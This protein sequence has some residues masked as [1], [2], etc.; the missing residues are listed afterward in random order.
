MGLNN[1]IL[2]GSLMEDL[3][4][5][6]LVE[7]SN[8]VPVNT[9]RPVHTGLQK[10]IQYLGKNKKQVCVLVNYGN[11]VYLPDTELNFL[12]SILQACKLNLG[13][14]AIVNCHAQKISF[15][16]LTEQVM[17]KYLLVFGVEAATIGLPQMPLFNTTVVDDC[18][19]VFAPAAE[20]LNNSQA[21]SRPLKTKLWL[22]LKQMFNVQ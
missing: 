22:C 16:E 7:D 9:I 21:A 18:H 2:S 14:V 1:I 13:D 8:P 10:T 6:H 20:Q 3:Y 5:N 12:T 15:K 19:I 11:D 4:K 17:C